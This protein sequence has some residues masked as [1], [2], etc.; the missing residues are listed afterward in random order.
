MPSNLSKVTQLKTVCVKLRLKPMNPHPNPFF[1]LTSLRL[2]GRRGLGE[3]P[4]GALLSIS[5]C[6]LL[7]SG[8][9]S[10]EPTFLPSGL[11]GD[12]RASEQIL[13][14][15]SHT[16]FLR[17]HNRLARELKR[18][19]PQWDGEKL[20]QEARKIL[21][22]FVQVRKPR[23]TASHAHLA[24]A[25][26]SAPFS[27]SP[28]PLPLLCLCCFF[29]PLPFVS[30]VP[31]PQN[32]SPDSECRRVMLCHSGAITGTKVSVTP[33]TVTQHLGGLFQLESLLFKV[34]TPKSQVTSIVHCY[35]R[36]AD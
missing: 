24:T 33:G 6:R 16:L 29:P 10:R 19:N 15:T 36:L 11:S 2:T 18:L 31:L 20:Y 5:L 21:G 26:G 35:S 23:S 17:E 28:P 8:G 25:P 3:G 9:C 32:E 14:A 30:L 4:S 12:S 34:F 22:A 13:L 1:H 7:G 27:V